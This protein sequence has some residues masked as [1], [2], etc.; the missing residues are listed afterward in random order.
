MET[1]PANKARVYL[2]FEPV[3]DHIGNVVNAA[4]YNQ[5]P[6]LDLKILKDEKERCPDFAPMVE[7]LEKG[8][9]LED[10]KKV[11]QILSSTQNFELLDGDIVHLFTTRTRNIKRATAVVKQLCIPTAYRPRIALEIHDLDFDRAYA[12]A[13]SRFYFSGRYTFFRG[14]EL[15]C[16]VCQQA[17]QPVHLG[18]T[19]TTS[20]AVPLP[21]TRWHPDHHTNFPA[22]ADGKKHVFVIID[23]TSMW[24][25]L[26]AVEG[27]DAETVIRAV[28]D[29]VVSRFGVPR[30]ISLLSDIGSAFISELKPLF[31]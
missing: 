13:R 1:T 18:K 10:D 15:T 19:P 17:K 31:C 16:S 27:T 14:H 21:G 25:E 28:F 9:P 8:K 24:P 26:I 2:E 30:G 6:S 7:C 12:R 5:Q 22:S 29:N 23:S 20:L 11:T 3:G 4:G